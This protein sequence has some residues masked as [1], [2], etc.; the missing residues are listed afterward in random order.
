[1]RVRVCVR[2]SERECVRES[3]RVRER[4][5]VRASERECVCERVRERVC[6]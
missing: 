6:E 1:M 5:C 2:A 3:G 4:L